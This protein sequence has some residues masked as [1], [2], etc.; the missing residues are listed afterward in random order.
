MSSI[1]PVDSTIFHGDFDEIEN[2]ATKSIVRRAMDN[3]SR[4]FSSL[5][6]QIPY[7]TQTLAE[8]HREIVDKCEDNLKPTIEE[9][10]TLK[11]KKQLTNINV[12]KLTKKTYICSLIQ[13]ICYL[14]N[15]N[16]SN[17]SKVSEIINEIESKKSINFKNVSSILKKHLPHLSYFSI[18][19]NYF[20]LTYIMNLEGW[21]NSFFSD[22]LNYVRENLKDGKNLPDAGKKILESLNI[23]IALYNKKIDQ[24]RDDRSNLPAQRDA[25][26]KQLFSDE[27]YLEGK[28]ETELQ[29][30]FSKNIVDKFIDIRFFRRPFSKNSKVKCNFIVE[31]LDRKVNKFIKLFLR[32]FLLDNIIP[33]MVNN[34]IEAIGSSVFKEAINQTFSD[35]MKD[36]LD[37]LGKPIKAKSDIDLNRPDI[38]GENLRKI[39]DELTTNIFKTLR[40]EKYKTQEDLNSIKERSFLEKTVDKSIEEALKEGLAK[41]YN[42]LCQ[43]EHS[44]K[45][46]AQIADLL[47][48]I[49]Q[50]PLKEGSIEERKQREHQKNLQKRFD[51]LKKI[52]IERFVQLS[53]DDEVNIAFGY[54]AKGQKE[55]LEFFYRKIKYQ[56][57]QDK[58]IPLNEILKEANELTDLIKLEINQSNAKNSK[59]KLNS[60]L[61]TIMSFIEKIDNFKPK[62]NGA[63]QKKLDKNFGPIVQQEKDLI[64]NLEELQKVL[65]KTYALLDIDERLKQIKLSIENLK[66]FNLLKQKHI[67][68]NHI[69]ELKK[70]NISN[71]TNEVLKSLIKYEYIINEILNNQNNIK[72]LNSIIQKESNKSLIDNLIENMISSFKSPLNKKIRKDLQLLKSIIEIEIKKISSKNDKTDLTIKLNNILSA[73]TYMQLADA[74]ETFEAELNDKIKANKILEQKNI[75]LIVE[76]S[77]NSLKHLNEKLNVIPKTLQKFHEKSIELS[78]EFILLLKELK[79]LMLNIEKNHKSTKFKKLN[80]LNSLTN[81]KRLIINL[82]STTVSSMYISPLIPI[83]N[84]FIATPIAGML[85]FSLSEKLITRSI[86]HITKKPTAKYVSDI[87]LEYVNSGYRLLTDQTFYRGLTHSSMLEA[88]KLLA[89]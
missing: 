6:H 63:L 27:K 23:Y 28:S 84:P 88:T 77:N 12:F 72:I 8:Q 79:N 57:D 58:D 33:S 50:P 7:N 42:I 81:T 41:V 64:I 30:L 39:L 11:E 9:A 83:L 60:L 32:S 21:L 19:K 1:K 66:N 29:Q 43:E 87:A 75:N 59:S 53:V 25:C 54:L 46:L 18:A 38:V 15:H 34:S 10:L 22:I 69:N 2:N 14:S 73:R 3:I 5:T 20:L 56:I 71:K 49:F 82:F 35:L 52:T 70:I 24:F 13:G 40:R 45:Y 89:K 31:Y 78:N 80:D 48:K 76:I 37:D 62:G 17:F 67:L 85:G 36:M 26:I 74:R 4:L 44:E 55:A 47:T 86:A 61:E 51:D 68:S 16:I 65:T